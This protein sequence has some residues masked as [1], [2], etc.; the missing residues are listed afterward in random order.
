MA[1]KNLDIDLI[2]L[3]WQ[4]FEF[5]FKGIKIRIVNTFYNNIAWQKFRNADKNI[6]ETMWIEKKVKLIKTIAKNIKK[7]D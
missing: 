7:K 5:N 1:K 6:L 2:E 3:D 4:N